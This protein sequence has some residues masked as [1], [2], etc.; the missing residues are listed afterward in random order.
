MTNEIFMVNKKDKSLNNISSVL[1]DCHMLL[2][3]SVSEKG[4]RVAMNIATDSANVEYVVSS[5]KEMTNFL[6]ELKERVNY[7]KE[8]IESVLEEIE[9]LEFAV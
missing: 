6:I 5:K 1:N 7:N 2:D 4:S 9:Y 8:D 3:F